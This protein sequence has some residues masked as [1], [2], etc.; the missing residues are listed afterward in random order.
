MSASVSKTNWLKYAQN[1]AAKASVADTFIVQRVF[2]IKMAVRP[3]Y[4]IG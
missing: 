3:F 1:I 4:S 2:L